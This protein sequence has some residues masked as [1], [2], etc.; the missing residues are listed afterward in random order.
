M[1]GL[2][3]DIILAFSFKSF[4]RA[5]H[6]VESLRWSRTVATVFDSTV[7]NPYIGCPSVKVR[8]TVDGSCQRGSDEVPFY[9][10]VSAKRYAEGFSGNPT[11]T[12]RVNPDN[13]NELL[14]FPYDQRRSSI[15]AGV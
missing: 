4:L 14:F 5:F 15:G 6:F 8:Y 11:V 3:I 2:I 13:P 7:L 12:V 1:G 10:R 9:L